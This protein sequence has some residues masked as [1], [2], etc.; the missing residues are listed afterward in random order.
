[1][2]A[3]L[4]NLHDMGGNVNDGCHLASMGGTWMMLTSGFGGLRGYDGT[5]SFWPRRAPEVTPSCAFP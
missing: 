4:I 2:A 5:L 1:M 3:L